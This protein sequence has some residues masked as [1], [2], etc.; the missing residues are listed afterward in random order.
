MSLQNVSFAAVFGPLLPWMTLVGRVEMGAP[1]SPVATPQPPASAVPEHALTLA[2]LQL[3]ER[4]LQQFFDESP[5]SVAVFEPTGQLVHLNRA[6]GAL[7]RY[8]PEDLLKHNID[9]L[10]HPADVPS[11]QERRRML[12]DGKCEEFQVEAR[13][14]TAN[15]HEVWTRMC[16]RLG[17]HVSDQPPH[18][19]AHIIDLTELKHTVENFQRD[20]EESRWKNWDSDRYV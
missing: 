15:Q 17:R 18:I 7:L 1:R 2:A 13:F 4:L 9:E 5:I 6:F 14:G 10:V 8:A 3:S 16:G 11:V 12:L 19:F 20:A